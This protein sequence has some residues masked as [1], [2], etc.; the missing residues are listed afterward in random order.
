LK[1]IELDGASILPG[2]KLPPEALRRRSMAA[3]SN[4]ALPAVCAPMFLVSGQDL[5]KEACRAG[6]V[7]TFPSLNARTAEAFDD[8][9][10]DISATT[11]QGAQPVYGVNLVLHASSNPR[12]DADVDLCVKHQ[13]PLVI[14]TLGVRRDV[15]ERIQAYGGLV[16]HDATTVRHA[17]KGA[18]AGVDGLILICAG[19]G[20]HSGSLS[21]F[22]FVP[23]VRRVF[24]GCIVV[25]GAISS[26]ASIA[27]VRMLGADLSY[28]GTRLIATR[29]STASDAHKQMILDGNASDVIYTPAITGVH[30]SFLKASL[31]AAGLDPAALPEKP[32][33]FRARSQDESAKQEGATAWKVIW[34][35]GQGIGNIDDVPEVADLIARLSR[36]YSAAMESGGRSKHLAK[37]AA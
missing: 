17:I 24:D 21:P 4:L 29:E 1:R 14:T 5:V 27:A 20:G 13:V 9:L 15:I 23:E 8:W 35:A 10:T 16:F 12:L 32:A 36:D 11:A 25:G 19:A 7:G 33:K 26:G 31:R 3:L 34:S 18:E 30:G 22:A 6:V 2:Y 28:L 37:G